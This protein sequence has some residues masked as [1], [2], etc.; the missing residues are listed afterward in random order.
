MLESLAWW[1]GQSLSICNRCLCTVGVLLLCSCFVRGGIV[2][3]GRG[4]G[5]LEQGNCEFAYV[6][7]LFCVAIGVCCGPLV[8][9]TC[10]WVA[11]VI[12]GYGR[13]MSVGEG[14]PKD[15][16]IVK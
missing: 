12:F 9:V 8:V 5:L 15:V 3:G 7:G 14:G 13:V 16:L 6:L 10:M 2:P 11:F 1:F 4:V